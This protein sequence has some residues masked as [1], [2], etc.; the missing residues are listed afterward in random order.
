MTDRDILF[1]RANTVLG[2]VDVARSS[3]Y[4]TQKFAPSRTGTCDVE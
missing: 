4:P 3:V 1:L 2:E